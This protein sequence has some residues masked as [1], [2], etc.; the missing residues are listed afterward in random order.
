MADALEAVYGA[1]MAEGMSGP[2]SQ[3]SPHSKVRL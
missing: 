2:P 3:F 1:I